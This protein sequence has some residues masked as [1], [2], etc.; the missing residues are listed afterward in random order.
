MIRVCL[1][2]RPIRVLTIGRL[3]VF[4]GLDIIVLREHPLFIPDGTRGTFARSTYWCSS[5]ILYPICRSFW[6]LRVRTARNVERW[7]SRE[8]SVRSDVDWSKSV[9]RTNC[10]RGDSRQP[11]RTDLFQYLLTTLFDPVRCDTPFT[12]HPRRKWRPI[13]F[14]IFHIEVG[15][16]FVSVRK[17]KRQS[18]RSKRRGSGDSV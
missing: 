12:S 13:L 2:V 15:A 1:E 6:K 9:D 11:P 3:A 4:N 5:Y 16:A 17:G 14:Y 8:G 18:T 7:S 10:L